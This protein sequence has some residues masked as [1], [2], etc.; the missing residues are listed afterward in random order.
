METYTQEQI[1]F[2]KS[3]V[4]E[5]GNGIAFYFLPSAKLRELVLK[6]E[7]LNVKTL[8]KA[9]VKLFLEG[10]AVILENKMV[11]EYLEGN[12]SVKNNWLLNLGEIRVV[13]NTF[14]LQKTKELHKADESW[15]NMKEIKHQKETNDV[16]EL[17]NNKEEI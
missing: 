13:S 4:A 5:H 14:K 6:G 12:A 3:Q 8:P 17:N 9:Y 2:I 1:S 16:V 11:I 7:H 15:E 10:K